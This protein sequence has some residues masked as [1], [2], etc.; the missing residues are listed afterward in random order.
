MLETDDAYVS[1]IRIIFNKEKQKQN[2]QNFFSKTY[3][4]KLTS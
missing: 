3:K 4:L 1:F 2:K